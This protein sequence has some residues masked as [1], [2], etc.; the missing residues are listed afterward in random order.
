[1]LILRE[2]KFDSYWKICI[3]SQEGEIEENLKN[4]ENFGEIERVW[5]L[6]C[7]ELEEAVCVPQEVLQ[8][9]LYYN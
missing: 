3:F 6:K 8:Y 2:T 7:K 9:R 4:G 1:M 5:E